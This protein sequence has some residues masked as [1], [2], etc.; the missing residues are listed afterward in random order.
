[1]L[2]LYNFVNE[3]ADTLGAQ[4]L[5]LKPIA[6]PMPNQSG[7]RVACQINAGLSPMPMNVYPHLS[8]GIDAG[9]YYFL[10][11]DIPIDMIADFHF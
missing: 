4:G 8:G 9:R 7:Q 6:L 10:R 1:M 5:G 11:G 2:R 3:I